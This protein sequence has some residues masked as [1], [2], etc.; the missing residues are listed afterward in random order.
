LIGAPYT[1]TG[2]TTF[3][4]PLVTLTPSSFSS[5][6]LW[7]MLLALTPALIVPVEAP[8]PPA[9]P[10]VPP[11]TDDASEALSSK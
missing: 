1:L 7:K 8:R 6:P 11:L 3:G 5:L 2:T 9:T 10:T 4:L